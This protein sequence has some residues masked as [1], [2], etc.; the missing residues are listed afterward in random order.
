MSPQ[1]LQEVHKLR[2]LQQAAVERERGLVAKIKDDSD[3]K[4]AYKEIVRAYEEEIKRLRAEVA[5]TKPKIAALKDRSN[6]SNS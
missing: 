2:E 3:K 6:R 4:R 5:N 1:V